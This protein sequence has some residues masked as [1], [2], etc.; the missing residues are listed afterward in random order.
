MPCTCTLSHHAWS[1]AKFLPDDAI[2][3]ALRKME[4]SN[5][6]ARAF[7]PGVARAAVA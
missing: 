6:R 5:S 7:L 2:V 4:D 1:G 3:F